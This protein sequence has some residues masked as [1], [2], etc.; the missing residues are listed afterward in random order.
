MSLR[1]ITNHLNT[2]RRYQVFYPTRLEDGLFQIKKAI[3]FYHDATHIWLVILNITFDFQNIS[4]NMDDI[5]HAL[6]S[7]KEEIDKK[8]M[9]LNLLSR[10]IRTPL[11]SIIGLT[12]I[13]EENPDNNTA[14]DAY[15][16]KISMS[17]TY[18]TETIEDILELR[19]IANHEIILKPEAILLSDFIG[20]IHHVI[21]PVCH[22]HELIFSLSTNI[23]PELALMADRHALYQILTKLLL[24]AMDYMVRGGRIQLNVQELLRKDNT[25]TIEFSVECPGII[26]EPE[27]L[28]ALFQPYD[29]LLNKVEED[30]TSLDIALIILKGYALAVGTDT[31]MAIADADKGTTVSLSLTMPLSENLLS[32]NK[33][34]LE[35]LL[36]RL[37]GLRVL[38]VDDN[39]TNL[40][41]GEKI[42]CSKGIDVVSVLNGKEAV[43]IY[44]QYKGHFD[45]IIMDIMMPVMDGLEAT[46]QI[47][48]LS[49]ISRAKTV[50]I[51]AMTANA[52]KESI[53]ES[54][55]AGM[56]AH[57]TKPI[58]PEKLFQAIANVLSITH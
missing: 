17:G 14:L 22:D 56:N 11:Q 7:T 43:N 50:P 35:E 34:S 46:R 38:L 13:V 18:M 44:T 16:H 10:N 52:L 40:E 26:I 4:D 9:F 51:I 3:F 39:E 37:K 5:H 8:N 55:K 15:L 28:K 57:L 24:S 47:R 6:N 25:V 49:D 45:V 21:E 27:R 23:T 1:C 2:D 33:M 32:S 58:S 42:L 19:K 48:S 54:F 30:I 29:Y 41:V 12:K 53:E 36:P 31:L 20:H